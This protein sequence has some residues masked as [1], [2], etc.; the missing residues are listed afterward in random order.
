MRAREGHE[1]KEDGVAAVEEQEK[2]ARI[3]G[4]EPRGAGSKHAEKGSFERRD[5]EARCCPR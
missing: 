4:K 3:D 2:D 1:E 5:T